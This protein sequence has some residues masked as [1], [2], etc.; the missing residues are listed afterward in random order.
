MRTIF[1]IMKTLSNTTLRIPLLVS[2][3]HL[4]LIGKKRTRTV[5]V[6]QALST[7]LEY[8][9][10]DPNKLLEVF[11]TDGPFEGSELDELKQRLGRMY[12]GWNW[13]GSS[14]CSVLK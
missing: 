4:M 12:L 8:D 13:D 7:T 1:A 9:H 11:F 10:N 6:G 3:K 14:T 5:P 2:F